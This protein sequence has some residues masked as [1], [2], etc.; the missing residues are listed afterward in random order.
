MEMSATQQ[1]KSQPKALPASL[2]VL[3]GIALLTGCG[4]S[5]APKLGTQAAEKARATPA[6]ARDDQHRASAA[7]FN[8]CKLVSLSEAQAITA[9]AVTSRIE[10]PLGPTC[11]YRSA[12]SKAEITVAVESIS[13][14]QVSRQMGK[15]K[16]LSVG[17]RNGYCG[18]LGTQM[19]FVPLTT[20]RVLH[21]TAPC[22]IAQQFAARALPRLAA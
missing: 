3:C 11:I 22:A 20:G 12:A 18:R 6:T 10:A 9:G 15:R 8:P 7:L 16:P 13:L 1:R 2:A 19:L 14:S 17:T 5:S 4:G 21:I